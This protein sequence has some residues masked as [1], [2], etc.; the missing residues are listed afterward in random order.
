MQL[1]MFINIRQLT[2]HQLYSDPGPKE[3]KITNV[4]PSSGI[5]ALE[6]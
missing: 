1:D 5:A 2:W 6:P 4:S 3:A